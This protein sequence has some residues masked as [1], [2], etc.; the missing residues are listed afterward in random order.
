MCC[1]DD[2]D[3]EEEEED[4]DFGEDEVCF[5]D[6][7]V[8]VYLFRGGSGEVWDWWWRKGGFYE[9]VVF[10]LVLGDGCLVMIEFVGDV[11]NVLVMV[12]SKKIRVD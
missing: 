5:V 1:G 4:G 7:D 8:D 9:V 3:V 6:D 11:W 10:D 12:L 2:E